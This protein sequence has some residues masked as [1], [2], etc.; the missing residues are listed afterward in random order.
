MRIL[1]A[2]LHY[3]IASGRYV[4]RAFRRLGHD[5]RTVGRSLGNQI[6]GMTVKDEWVW[7][8]TDIEDDW[9]PDLHIIVDSSPNIPVGKFNCPRIIWGVDNHMRD[10]RV[11]GEVDALFLAHSFG[12][13]MGESNVH[14]LPCAYDPEAHTDIGIERNFEAGMCAVPYENRVEL[15]RTMRAAGINVI[16]MTGLLWEDYN[17]FYNQCKIA[18]VRSVCGDLAQRFFENMAQGCCVLAD[19][20]IDAEKLGFVAGVDYWP[21]DTPEEAA[22]EAKHLLES[23]KWQEIAENGKR[24]VRGHTW[25]ARAIQLLGTMGLK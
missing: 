1:I 19:R 17:K 8:P 9:E 6:W 4:A 7:N 2:C 20:T 18:V 12:A 10:Y 24:K 16:A 3:P 14:H 5:V 13:R 23:G 11:F 25:D 22:R 15:V 21:Y